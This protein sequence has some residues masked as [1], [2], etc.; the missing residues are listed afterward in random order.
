MPRSMSTAPT[1]RSHKPSAVQKWHWG[2]DS[3]SSQRQW[4]L[5]AALG[6]IVFMLA[7]LATFLW[8]EHGLAIAKTGDRAVRHSAGLAQDL[9]QTLNIAR[10]VISQVDAQLRPAS[11]GATAFSGLPKGDR[12]STVLSSLPLPFQLHAIG[13]Q[14]RAIAVAETLVQSATAEQ[15]HR[16]PA[17]EPLSAERWGLS[18]VDP[19]S[20]THMVPLVWKAATNTEGVQGY[21]V[22][23]SLAALRAWLERE[24]IG[25][26]DR[27]SLFWM[28]GDGTATLL[29]RAP[30][31][32]NENGQRLRAPWMADTQRSA[33]GIVEQ[34]GA[35]DGAPR[36][37]AFHRLS[38]RRKWAC[39]VT[40]SPCRAKCLASR[41]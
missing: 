1:D 36:L 7:A 3:I 8:R 30:A 38:G 6:T 26:D 37:A 41:I 22:D 15:T 11:A 16:H 21:A 19:L 34:R 32:P 5:A 23:L 28:N 25:S 20:Q 27:V 31:E 18:P 40:K 29:A 35:L 2:E 12:F 10:T 13:P 9:E 14:G 39:R 33:D 24:R 4:L 17:S